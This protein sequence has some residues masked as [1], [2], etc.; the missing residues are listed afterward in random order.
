MRL[1]NKMV[2]LAAILTLFTGLLAAPNAYADENGDAYFFNRRTT[3]GAEYALVGPHSTLEAANTAI[4]WSM[5]NGYEVEW[6]ADGSAPRILVEGTAPAEVAPS[7]V[8]V[9]NKIVYVTPRYNWHYWNTYRYY[10]R[11]WKVKVRWYGWKH[12]H[13]YK[14]FKLKH[15]HHNHHKGHKHN[16]DWKWK[17][18]KKNN[19]KKFKKKVKQNKF[20][21]AKKK[22]KKFKFKKKGRKKG[23]K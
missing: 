23:K 8:I 21:K 9:V 18:L 1:I 20:K 12:Y 14:H 11:N 10:W 7:K 17:K 16:H 22:T 3:E 2:L 5:D 15:K 19:N 13:G 4:K 6:E